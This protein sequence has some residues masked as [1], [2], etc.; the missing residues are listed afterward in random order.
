MLDVRVSRIAVFVLGP[1]GLI[2]H[3][4]PISNHEPEALQRSI[5]FC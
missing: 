2:G 5:E 1:I 3:I 4:G